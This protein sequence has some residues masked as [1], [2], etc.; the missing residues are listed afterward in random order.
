VAV[1]TPLP[2]VD[3]EVLRSFNIDKHLEAMVYIVYSMEYSHWALS[4]HLTLC[5]LWINSEAIG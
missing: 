2:R 1:A 3:I 4:Y 5:T